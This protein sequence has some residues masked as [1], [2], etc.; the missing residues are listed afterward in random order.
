LDQV[1]FT[2]E[3]EHCTQYKF[4]AVDGGNELTKDQFSGIIGLAPPSS[5][6]KSTIPAF[7]T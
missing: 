5:E 1:C 2:Q 6:E 4:L 7:V 3:T